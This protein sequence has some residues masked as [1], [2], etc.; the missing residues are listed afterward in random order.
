MRGIHSFIPVPVFVLFLGGDSCLQE[1]SSFQYLFN[2]PTH[3][4]TLRLVCK[5]ESP[6]LKIIY[7]VR[8]HVPGWMVTGTGDPPS[9]PSFGNHSIPQSGILSPDIYICTVIKWCLH[10]WDNEKQLS[11]TLGLPRTQHPT[12][13]KIKIQY[14]RITDRS[15]VIM[16]QCGSTKDKGRKG[17]VKIGAKFCS[18]ALNLT[19]ARK[20][21]IPSI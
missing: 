3:A 15:S 9:A 20:V 19:I 7:L 8:F 4:L 6:P 16:K 13:I 18:G 2:S 17:R 21:K 11:P 5:F 1:I 14:H 12:K 10:P